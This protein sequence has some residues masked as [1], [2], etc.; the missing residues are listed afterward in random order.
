VKWNDSNY[1]KTGT[2]WYYGE[3]IYPV[4]NST[5]KYDDYN[6]LKSIGDTIINNRTCYKINHQRNKPLCYGFEQEAYVYQSN[7]TLYFLNSKTEKFV[8]LYVYGANKGDSWT[9]EYPSGNVKVVVD[10]ISSVEALGQTLKLQYVRYLYL[11]DNYS[12]VSST[13][14]SKIITNIG[15][16]NYLFMSNIFA[17]PY[18]DEF[19]VAHKGLRCYVHPDY[20]T[21]KIGT[22]D[23]SY[24]TAIPEINTSPVKV[25]I[26]LSG[27]LKIES[28]LLSNRCT[29]ELMDVRGIVILRAGVN[30]TLNTVLL[31]NLNSG[32][33]IYRLS[34]NGKLLK[35]DKIVK[36]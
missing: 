18:C 9:V 32:L 35:T 17:L 36:F 12:T 22:L 28:E 10:S 5:I 20:G 34:S 1:L 33:Y 14:E 24:V 15:D 31:G 4:Y 21:Y 27:D 19:Q 13:Y 29:F 6:S 26:N 11:G 7:D 8:P 23:C 2:Q 3:V 25:Y 30:A 16:V